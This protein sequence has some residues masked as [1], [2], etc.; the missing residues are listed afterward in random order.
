MIDRLGDIIC[1]FCLPVCWHAT[2]RRLHDFEQV[3]TNTQLLFWGDCLDSNAFPTRCSKQNIHFEIRLLAWTFMEEN[4]SHWMT[5]VRGIFVIMGKHFVPFGSH[6]ILVWKLF[7]K[8]TEQPDEKMINRA[9]VSSSKSERA[10]CDMIDCMTFACSTRTNRQ[11]KQTFNITKSL[12]HSL[13]NLKAV[14][15]A[16]FTQFGFTVN[17]VISCWCLADDVSDKSL[18]S[19]CSIVISDQAQPGFSSPPSIQ[20]HNFSQLANKDGP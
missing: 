6:W 16:S 19:L 13:V 18:S 15:P 11:T 3:L 10:K 20:N 2:K 17:S 4:V 14:K 5:F 12:N 1:L 9:W 8:N 7:H